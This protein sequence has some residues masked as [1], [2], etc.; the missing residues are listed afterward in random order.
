MLQLYGK[1][2]TLD[3]VMQIFSL[4]ND[5]YAIFS[6]ASPSVK[7]MRLRIQNFCVICVICGS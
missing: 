1:D 3:I 5:P 7:F 2:K 4:Q 6:C